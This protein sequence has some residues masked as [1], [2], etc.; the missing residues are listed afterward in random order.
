ML[1]SGFGAA[2]QN[3]AD[4][5]G[6]GGKCFECLEEVVVRAPLVHGVH[7]DG[8][9]IRE[10]EKGSWR[11]ESGKMNNSMQ[12]QVQ[13]PGIGDGGKLYLGLH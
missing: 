1:S 13:S 9:R 10:L 5:A 6:E 3:K 11:K 7:D 2:E 4:K 8:E 12:L